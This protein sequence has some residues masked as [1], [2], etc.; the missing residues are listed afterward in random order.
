MG[1]VIDKLFDNVNVY[2][3]PGVNRILWERDSDGLI[4]LNLIHVIIPP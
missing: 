3:R 4:V 2:N 1:F